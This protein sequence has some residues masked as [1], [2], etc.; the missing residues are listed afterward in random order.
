MILFNYKL[1][2]RGQRCKVPKALHSHI[3]EATE[4]VLSIF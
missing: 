4:L 1:E 3:K 2:R